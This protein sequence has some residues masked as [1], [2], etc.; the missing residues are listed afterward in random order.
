MERYDNPREALSRANHLNRIIGR[1]DYEVAI[2]LD[3]QFLV[4]RMIPWTDEFLAWRRE[5]YRFYQGA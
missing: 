1:R 3:G 2:E 4:R 5:F